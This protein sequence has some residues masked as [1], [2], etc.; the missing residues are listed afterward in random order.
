VWQE[1]D[2]YYD[3]FL[4]L[5]RLL[6]TGKLS[7]HFGRIVVHLTHIYLLQDCLSSA[8][9]A[10]WE[11]VFPFGNIDFWHVFSLRKKIL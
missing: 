4:L 10:L 5:I 6:A 9:N 1:N 2:T 3:G 7:I 11:R 8:A